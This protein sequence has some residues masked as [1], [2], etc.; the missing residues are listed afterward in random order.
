[1]VNSL[2]AMQET[3]IQS[4]GG[5]DPLGRE[6]ATH[7]SV[8]AWEIPWMEEPAWAVSMGLPRVGHG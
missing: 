2:P 3:R 6:M 4:P 1:M 7:S 5:E 8:L